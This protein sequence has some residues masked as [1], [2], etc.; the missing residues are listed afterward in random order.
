LAQSELGEHFVLTG[1]T[2]LSAFF[3][4]HRVSED[5]DLFSEDDTPLQVVNGFLQNV[6]GLRVES[7]QRRYDRKMFTVSVDGFPLK[8]EFTKFP[9]QHAYAKVQVAQTLWVDSPNEILLNKL[10]AMTDRREPKDDVDLYFLLRSDGAPSLVQATKLAEKKFGIS[11]LRYSLQ[12]RLLSVPKAL[13]NTTPPVA[14]DE[15]VSEFRQHVNQ[16]IAAFA[17]D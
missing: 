1:G 2:A 15:V 12:S 9:F 17:T 8:V 10:L 14:R 6:P 13:P 11:G 7:Y 5:L 4:G 3:F 16:L